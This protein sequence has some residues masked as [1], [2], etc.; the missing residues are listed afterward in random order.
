MKSLI[1]M[2]ALSKQLATDITVKQDWKILR[3][4]KVEVCKQ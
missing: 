3:I 4:E 2:A 1:G